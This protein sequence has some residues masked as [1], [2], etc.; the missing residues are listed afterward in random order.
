MTARAMLQQD[1]Y[2]TSTTA[3]AATIN[4]SLTFSKEKVSNW[5]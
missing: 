3:A 1:Y 2:S 5:L 4:R